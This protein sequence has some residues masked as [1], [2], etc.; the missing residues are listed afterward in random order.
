[1]LDESGLS[2]FSSGPIERAFLVLQTVAAATSPLGV[3]E[4]GRRCGLPRSTAARLAV[5]LVELG[6]LTRSSNGTLSSGPAIET[7]QGVGSAG[8]AL[9]Y[10]LRPLLLELVERY[11]ESVALT[12]DSAA[13]AHYLAQ[14]TGP[15]AVKVPDSTGVS[16]P[17]HVV[18]PGLTLMAA[19]PKDRLDAYLAEPLAA[20]TPFTVTDPDAIRT[21]LRR[22]RKDGFVWTDQDLDLEVNG[23]AVALT[24]ASG[25]AAAVS[26]YGPAY[27][28]NPTDQPTLAPNVVRLVAQRTS[29][30]LG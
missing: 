1:M 28:L 21:R 11:G 10:R 15:S 4:L 5:Q 27:R 25:V 2:T 16:L 23:L 8:A 19:W 3:R 7:L 13:G 18:A 9:E 17:F 20:A 12:V 14:I 24:P 26:L 30:L 22:A 6:M 29:T